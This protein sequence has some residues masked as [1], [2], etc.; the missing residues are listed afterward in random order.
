MERA[1]Q[2]SDG[3]G[4][5][6]LQHEMTVAAVAQAQ[7][8]LVQVH[9]EPGQ[10]IVLSADVCGQDQ[11]TQVRLHVPAEGKGKKTVFFFHSV[12]VCVCGGKDSG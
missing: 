6:D 1:E 5:S 2:L 7:V 10:V 8:L 4:G 11:G 12:C 3:G 9:S